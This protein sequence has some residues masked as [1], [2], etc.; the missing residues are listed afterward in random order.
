VILLEGQQLGTVTSRLARSLAAAQHLPITG[1]RLPGSLVSPSVGQPPPVYRRVQRR[2]REQCRQRPPDRHHPRP[3]VHPSRRQ[4]LLQRPSQGPQPASRLRG[5]TEPH[6]CPRALEHPAAVRNVG[7]QDQPHSALVPL[8][9]DRMTGCSL[10][11]RRSSATSLHRTGCRTAG[12]A[13]ACAK[14]A[15]T[16][17]W[18]A[19]RQRAAR[20]MAGGN[21]MPAASG[22][23]LRQRGLCRSLCRSGLVLVLAVVLVLRHCMLSRGFC[24][25]TYLPMRRAARLRHRPTCGTRHGCGALAE[26]SAEPWLCKM[27]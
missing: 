8:R 1:D 5:G 24:A 22:R 3:V 16:C 20:I 15:K 4:A 19:T 17:A 11:S 2:R 9:D 10:P 7:C 12:G 13:A 21:T 23:G 14:A 27:T 26:H 18:P 6:R 25:C